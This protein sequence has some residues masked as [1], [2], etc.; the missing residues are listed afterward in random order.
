MSLFGV[1]LE[2]NKAKGEKQK[3]KPKYP[4]RT[5]KPLTILQAINRFDPTLNLKKED[6][7]NL[8]CSPENL[9][10]PKCTCSFIEFVT[11]QKW[12]TKEYVEIHLRN[13]I[14]GSEAKK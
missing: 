1:F 7:C 10:T 3:M 9:K 14:L 11:K 2:T 12:F 4:S 5:P 8:Q 13:Q 6:F